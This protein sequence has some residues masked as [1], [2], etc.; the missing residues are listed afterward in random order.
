MSAAPNPTLPDLLHA[1]KTLAERQS[2]RLL[3]YLIE[4]ALIESLTPQ[5]VGV[6]R[7]PVK[8]RKSALQPGMR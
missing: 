5:D 1:A 6:H 3:I 7:P 2:N 8:A 4:M